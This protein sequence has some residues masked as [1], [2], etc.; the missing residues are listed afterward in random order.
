M[1]AFKIR[2]VYFGPPFFFFI[3]FFWYIFIKP[4]QLDEINTYHT[5]SGT[6]QFDFLPHS[7]SFTGGTI[8][9]ICIPPAEENS[10]YTIYILTLKELR[11]CD[12]F[13]NVSAEQADEIIQTLYQLSALCYQAI[14]NERTSKI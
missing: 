12:G 4:H 2:K 7:T 8:T 1:A 5:F 14:M 3:V 13:A 11:S 6:T 9:D 10:E